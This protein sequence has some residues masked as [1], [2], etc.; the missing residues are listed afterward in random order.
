MPQL[1]SGFTVFAHSVKRRTTFSR[2]AASPVARDIRDMPLN[3]RVRRQRSGLQEIPA[4]HSVVHG[5]L[6]SLRVRVFKP[7]QVRCAFLSPAILITAGSATR[8]SLFVRGLVPALATSLIVL[9][10]SAWKPTSALT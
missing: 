6:L 7:R 10:S 1:P 3:H 8:R 2:I 9:T 5:F 4:R